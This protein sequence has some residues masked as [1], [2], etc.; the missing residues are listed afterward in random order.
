MILTYGDPAKLAELAK[1]NWYML[2]LRS[3]K[4]VESTLKR[5]GTQLPSIFNSNA[6]EIFIPVFRRD[7][8]VFE[9]KTGNYIFARSKS[10]HGLLRLK[11]VTGVVGLVTMGDTN[12]PSK[13]IPVDD[14]YV[15]G[16]I[17]E[18][19]AFFQERTRGITL[20]SFVRIIDG[21]QRN[22]CGTVVEL[23]NGDACVKVE[24]K[25][26]ILIVET[27]VRNLLD[28][29]HVPERFRVFYFAPVV[30][31]MEHTEEEG[32]LFEDLTYQ[33]DAAYV[34]DGLDVQQSKKHGRQ[35]TVTALV[36]RQILTGTLSPQTIAVEV[37]QALKDGRLKKPK[38][39]SI[40]HGII[41]HRLI[42]DYFQKKNPAIANYREVIT[43][44]GAEWKFPLHEFV[45]L[46]EG[47]NLPVS[48]SD[49]EEKV[50]E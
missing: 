24:I 38:N 32:L 28:L 26:K 41:K 4:T 23:N 17:A 11:T 36:K 20:G 22:F 48:S 14:E 9:L 45:A 34:D 49:S 43:Q 7:I 3:E 10:F 15:Q 1:T 31:A 16:I 40:V 6:V 42:V 35:Q 8:N 47:L 25:T 2:E 44:F 39:L 37:V 21:E 13:V 33:E 30:E 12:H 46:G 50:D 29:S 5:L 19:Q 27:P 18:A